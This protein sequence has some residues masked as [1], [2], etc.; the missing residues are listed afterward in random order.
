MILKTIND[1]LV[2]ITQVLVP[3]CQIKGK[4]IN[5]PI[6]APRPRTDP[7]AEL[8]PHF[9]VTPV[10]LHFM[11][12]EINHY[13]RIDHIATNFFHCHAM[14]SSLAKVMSLQSLLLLEKTEGPACLDIK[15]ILLGIEISFTITSAT[16]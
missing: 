1:D 3:P 14:I 15:N 7:E 6:T 9:H 5:R 4:S 16:F 10:K 8:L 2:C 12:I 13:D 11:T